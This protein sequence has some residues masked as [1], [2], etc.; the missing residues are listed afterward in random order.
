[1]RRLKNEKSVKDLVNLDLL[2]HSA[3]VLQAPPAA[4]VAAI[5][6]DYRSGESLN[7]NLGKLNRF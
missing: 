1:M 2:L 4:T 3:A 6:V 7:Y 5:R